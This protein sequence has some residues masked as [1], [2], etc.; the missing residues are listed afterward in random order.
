MAKFNLLESGYGIQLV[1]NNNGVV[2]FASFVDDDMD[3]VYLGDLVNA[4][5]VW[6]E[7][8][9]IDLQSSE[10]KMIALSTYIGNPYLTN[11]QILTEVYTRQFK[12]VVDQNPDLY[13]YT[14]KD[15][16][17]LDE[18]VEKM[19]TAIAD[20]T[21]SLTGHAIELTLKE[22]GLKKQPIAL[23]EWINA[24]TPQEV[25]EM[26]E[27]ETSMRYS[28][29]DRQMQ[30]CL[31]VTGWKNAID[32]FKKIHRYPWASHQARNDQESQ[33][34]DWKNIDRNRSIAFDELMKKYRD[35]QGL[36]K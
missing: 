30:Q 28:H 31:I 10:W 25:L 29:L 2:R 23:S 22:L 26:L 7:E 6:D 16:F 8:V 1:K 11:K 4:T 21:A 33:F 20:S 9:K 3:L 13:Q 17:N 12:R 35:S 5:I 18:F 14:Q 19:V 36:S 24:P 27:N 32:K 15:E 34:F